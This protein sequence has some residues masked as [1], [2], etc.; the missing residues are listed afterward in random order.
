MGI[1]ANDVGEKSPRGFES[2]LLR[3][4]KPPQGGF[5]KITLF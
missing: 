5:Y 3:K 4:R 2:L 1:T